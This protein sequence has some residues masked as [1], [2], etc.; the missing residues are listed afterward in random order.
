[1]AQRRA[2]GRVVVCVFDCPA[3][4]ALRGVVEA[5]PAALD[6]WIGEV[7]AMDDRLVARADASA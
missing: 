6:D 5:L 2:P 3:E 4:G 7:V 1:M